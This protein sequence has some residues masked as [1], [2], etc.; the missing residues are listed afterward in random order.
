[1]SQPVTFTIRIA[2]SYSAV[3]AIIPANVGNFDKPAYV[4][5]VP[6]K[7]APDSYGMFTQKPGGFV[8]AMFD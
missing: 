7:F 1:M 3:I 5:L 8:I 6:V 2:T 4:Y